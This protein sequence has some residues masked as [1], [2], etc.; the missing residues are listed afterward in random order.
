MSDFVQLEY[1][2]PLKLLPWKLPLVKYRIS[3]KS[4]GTDHERDVSPDIKKM[5]IAPANS[6][7][8]QVPRLFRNIFQET[9]YQILDNRIA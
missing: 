3:T 1:L 7:F 9:Q 4:P 5:K 2:T 6:S 8:S